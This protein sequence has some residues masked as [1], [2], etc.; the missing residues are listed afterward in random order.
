MYPTVDS[1][2]QGVGETSLIE[3]LIRCKILLIVPGVLLDELD[4]HKSSQYW[5]NKEK[6]AVAQGKMESV[7]HSRCERNAKRCRDLVRQ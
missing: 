1:N 2:F 5:I 6:R 3:E 4:S 7:D